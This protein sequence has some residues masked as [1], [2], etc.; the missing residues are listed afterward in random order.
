[1]RLLLWTDWWFVYKLAVPI[2]PRARGVAVACT[3]VPSL[4]TQSGIKPTL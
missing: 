2:E 1:V 3:S 4:E